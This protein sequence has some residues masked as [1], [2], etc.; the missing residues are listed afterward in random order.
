MATYKVSSVPE[1][2]VVLGIVAFL[3]FLK[4]WLIGSL[5]VS[6]VK[7]ISGQCGGHYAV[8]GVLS[9]DWFCVSDSD[10]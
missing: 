9:G 7:A 5:L 3:A 4:M 2:I 1:L 6:S 10:K 8:E